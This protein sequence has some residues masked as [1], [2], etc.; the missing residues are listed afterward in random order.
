MSD[1]PN[2]T[3]PGRIIAHRGA[4][5]IA[6]E[7]TLAAFRLAAEQGARWIEFDV[8]LLGDGTPV[9]IHDATLDRCSD[10]TTHI[11]EITRYDLSGIDAGSWKDPDF[12]DE[13][14][15]T[16]AATLDEIAALD[17]YAN[18]ELKPHDGDTG[19]LARAT[20]DVLRSYDWARDRIITSSFSQSELT[21]FRTELPEAPIAM[22]FDRAPNDWQEIM[23]GLR[24]A[25]M[26]LNWQYLSQSLLSEVA[27]RGFDLRVYTINDPEVIAP[28]RPHG[29]TS[30]I[31]DHP[32]LY[33]DDAE[34]QS[35]IGS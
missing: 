10:W 14:I 1:R 9:V 26:H 2:C 21:A 29:L 30:I 24:A 3:D 34:W 23:T 15:P 13:T 19:L 12:K 22:L 16:L 20:A 4:S 6:P 32:P 8:S 25:A 7:N 18:L 33:L 35:W 31:T 28:F 5:E 17:L 27:S 11:S